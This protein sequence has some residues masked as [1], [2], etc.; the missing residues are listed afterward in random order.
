MP[1]IEFSRN[2]DSLLFRQVYYSFYKSYLYFCSYY[3]PIKIFSAAYLL[4]AMDRN[5]DPC[6][7]FFQYACG[8]WNRKHVIPEDRSSIST[9]EVM[10]DQLQVIL[11]G[12]L[13][14]RPTKEDNFATTK[15]KYFYQ[16]CM[17]MCKSAVCL[18]FFQSAYLW[19]APNSHFTIMDSGFFQLKLLKSVILRYGE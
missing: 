2:I 15:A 17:N 3:L 9:F 19:T 13:E 1:R 6:H 4:S 14:Q 11:K 12:I 18:H 8:S 5:A 16:S 7:D 10:A